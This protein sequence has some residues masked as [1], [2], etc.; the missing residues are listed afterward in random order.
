[1]QEV[2]GLADRVLVMRLGRISG[3]VSGDDMTED[4]I[5]RLAM[6]LGATKRRGGIMASIDT[7]PKTNPMLDLKVLGPILA[8]VVLIIVG[9]SLNGN[10]LSAANIT[11]VLSRSAFIGIIAVGMT[12]VITAG[13]L[14]LSVGSMAAFIAGL[15]ILVMNALLPMMGPGV[16]LVIVGMLVAIVAGT[17]AGMVNGFLDHHTCGLRRFIVTLGTMG[18]YRSL[19]TWLGGWWH[20][21]A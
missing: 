15:M 10:F 17:A 1:M 6:G 4:K 9:A 21:V 12:F 18:I 11:N 14:D 5:V 8:L 19:V 3:E 7:A 16:P 2:I 13:G 20:A